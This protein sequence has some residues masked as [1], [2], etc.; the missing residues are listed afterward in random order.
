MMAL[1]MTIFAVWPIIPGSIWMLLLGVSA[2]APIIIHLL[3]K[4]KYNETTWAAMTYLLAAIQKNARRIQIEQILL[5]AV[6]IAILL[7]LALGLADLSCNWS[8]RIGPTLIA[9]GTTHTVLVLDGSYSMASKRTARDA[10]ETSKQLAIDLV[11]DGNQGDGFTLV[12]MSDP[13][14]VIVAEPAF[15]PKDVIE[16]I[17]SLRRPDA[18]ADLSAT[19]A[20]VRTVLDAAQRDHKRLTQ[21]RVCFFTDLQGTTWDDAVTDQRREEIKR[22]SQLAALV[23][24]DLGQPDE[25]NLAVTNLESLEPYVTVSRDVAFR[26]QVRN[27]GLQ[28]RPRCLVE[29]FVD[30]RRMQQRYVSVAAGEETAVPFSH[31]FEGPGDHDVEARL[32]SDALKVDNH[33]YLSVP[34]KESIR[35]LCIAGKPGSARF[36]QLALQ[37]ARSDRPRIRPDVTAETALLETDL[38]TYDCVFL[39]NVGRFGRNEAGVLHDYLKNGGALVFFLGDQV[40]P[41]SYNLELGGELSGK[42]VLPARIGA[43]AAEAQYRFDPRDYGHPIVAPFRGHERTGLLTTPVW[44]YYRLSPY[45]DTPAKVAL[46]FEDGD[47]AIVEEPI[48]RGRSIVVATAASDRSMDRKTTPPTPFTAMSSWHSFP[49]LVQ[50]MLSLAVSGRGEGRNQTVGRPLTSSIHSTDASVPLKIEDPDQRT[51]R[52]RMTIDGEDS[53][54][55]FAGTQR[56]GIYRARYGPPVAREER[57]AVNVDTRESDLSRTDPDQLPRELDRRTTLDDAE[58]PSISLGDPR[59]KLFRYLLGAMLALLFVETLLAWHFGNHSL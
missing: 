13:P 35:V 26:A 38:N 11:R 1:A 51:E 43:L 32:D 40:L 8:G 22:L 36:V 33:R 34:V 56:S 57:F 10:F 9:G 27:L 45:E 54:W 28:D 24:V 39:C 49:P 2:V 4:R 12:L 50:E 3:S 52:V 23:L 53:R 48:Q 46:W 18:G 47:P 37:P 25:E 16:E 6:R 41:D 31:R 44:R 20:E 7:L 29:F 21:S 42:R 15:D 5:L 30:G 59:W 17:E 14:R 55:I 58:E 19:L